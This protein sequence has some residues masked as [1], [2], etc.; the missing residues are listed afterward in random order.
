[1]NALLFL[2]RLQLG[3]WL[4]FAFSGL[5]TLRGALLVV[6]TLSVLLPWLTLVVASPFLGSSRPGMDP[7]Q[8]QRYGPVALLAY[9][10]AGVVF[11]PSSQPIYFSPAE[12][13]FL[14]AG[15][16]SRRQ[17]I[18]YKLILS[19][20]TSLPMAVL[21]SLI[22]RVEGAWYGGVLLGALLLST[23]LVLFSI[24]L[25]L[26]SSWLG[27]SLHTR[28][29][30]L[31]AILAG[32][33]LLA[34]GV[35]VWQSQTGSVLERAEALLDSSVWQTIAWPI[36]S[37]FRLISVSGPA[38]LLEPLAVAVA[39]NGGIGLLIFGLDA[40]FL[41]QSAAGSA[42]LYA[43]LLRARGQRVS[44]EPPEGKERQR[45]W[46]LPSLPYW[47]GIGPIVWRQTL[48][49]VRSIG[50]VAL[51]MLVLGVALAGPLVAAMGKNKPE[52]LIGVLVGVLFWLSIVLPILVPFD[53]R[54]DID[55]MATLKSLPIA[56]W[57]LALGQILVPAF[58]LSL[59][60]GFIVLGVACFQIQYVSYMLMG[61]FLLPL[62]NLYV[63]AVENVLFLF[64]PVRIAAATPGDFQATGRNILLSLGKAFGLTIPAVAGGGGFLLGY[65]TGW[66]WLGVLFTSALLLLAVALLVF[67]AGWAFEQFDVGRT[68]PA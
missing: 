42:A 38:E 2:L 7:E 55:R 57:R 5:K 43:R 49:A 21:L 23:F 35:S 30:V 12:V 44:L 40:Q 13:Q 17:L 52:I 54:G 63:I 9:I 32:L 20:L 37:F 46:T 15:P 67:V 53:F 39:L 50:R 22:V 48:T 11:S 34:L 45:S 16:F 6:L 26:L 19:L 1:M 47:G 8:L 36:A 3:G 31:V 60:Q 25:G 18:L 33:A 14:F 27:A 51:L 64:F 24:A 4:R 61:L 56:P 41:E 28:T 66:L 29:R 68:T 58:I 10:I 59:A 65:L 62:F